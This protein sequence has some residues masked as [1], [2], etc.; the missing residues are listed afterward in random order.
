MLSP[1]RLQFDYSLFLN[2]EAELAASG[3]TRHAATDP[4]GKPCRLPARVRDVLA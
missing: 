1:V 3:W 2:G 4:A